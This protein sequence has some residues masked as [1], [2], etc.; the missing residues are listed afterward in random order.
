MPISFRLI[1]EISSSFKLE[2][3]KFLNSIFPEDAFSKPPI[4]IIKLVFPDPL[5][6]TTDIVS[7]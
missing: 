7:L 2:I 6:P 5:S 1:S 3:S 4:S